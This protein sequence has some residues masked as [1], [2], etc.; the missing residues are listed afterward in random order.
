MKSALRLTAIV[1]LL[2]SCQNEAK[3]ANS[4]E[5]QVDSKTSSELS[6]KTYSEPNVEVNFGRIVFDSGSGQPVA[7]NT[8]TPLRALAEQVKANPNCNK[9]SVFYERFYNSGDYTKEI[10]I[11]YNR[12]EKVVTETIVVSKVQEIYENVDDDIISAAYKANEC[13][14]LYCLTAYS[15]TAVKTVYPK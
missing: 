3:Q 15:K 8:I 5:E 2:V 4:A 11:L 9:I 13:E 6:A 12:T 7:E 10:K 14:V 1:I